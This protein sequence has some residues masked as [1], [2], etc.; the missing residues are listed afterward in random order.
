MDEGKMADRMR[1]DLLHRME[2]LWAGPAK[3]RVE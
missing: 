1:T 3:W 2:A